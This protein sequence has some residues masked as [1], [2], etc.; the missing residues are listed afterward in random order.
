MKNVEIVKLAL[1]AALVLAL[2]VGGVTVATAGHGDLSYE[3]LFG[4]PLFDMAGGATPFDTKA[5]ASN[6]DVIEIQGKGTLSIRRVDEGL[7]ER[8]VTGGGKFTH[9]LS[10]G[11]TVSGIWEAKQLLLF[12]H[13][14]PTPSREWWGRDRGEGDPC[15]AEEWE[16]GRALIL[17]HLTVDGEQGRGFDA[18]L[19]IGCRLP[20]NN[21]APGAI[22][23]VAGTIEGVRLKMEGGPDFNHAAEPMATLFI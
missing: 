20:G 11:D 12:D 21:G 4:K 9:N 2:S 16:S 1:T 3:Y 22:P 23:G 8:S 15:C 10:N 18:V 19:E 14:G 6:G 7:V 5:T 17:V 13:Y